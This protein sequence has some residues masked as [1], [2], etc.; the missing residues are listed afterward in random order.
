MSEQY[1]GVREVAR[2]I[3]CRPRDLS[4]GLY[5]GTL[6]AGRCPLVAGR[7]LI[8]RDYVPEIRKALRERRRQREERQEAETAAM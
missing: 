7:R 2:Q 5:D 3:G 8:P 6:D 4:D 1:L